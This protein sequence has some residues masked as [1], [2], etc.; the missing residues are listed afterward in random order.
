[1]TAPPLPAPLPPPAPPP[2][3]PR[4]NGFAVAALVCGLLGGAPLGIA[5]GIIALSRIRRRPQA[6]RGLAVGGLIASGCWLLIFAA[7]AVAAV[8]WWERGQADAAV[9]VTPRDRVHVSA[10]A[11]GDCVNELHTEAEEVLDMP[12]VPCD[13]PHD[14]EVYAVFELPAGPFPGEEAVQEEVTV[15]CED[16]LRSFAGAGSEQLEFTFLYP[17]TESFWTEDRQVT[18]IAFDP[19]G[20]RSSSARG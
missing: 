9:A 15:R 7:A 19:D 6:G 14:G 5:F 13:T 4:P 20:Q 12:V 3:D 1:M 16:D 10:L 2:V 17:A 8:L 11:P 18:C